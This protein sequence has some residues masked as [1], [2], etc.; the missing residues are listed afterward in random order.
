MLTVSLAHWGPVWSWN[1]EFSEVVYPG[2]LS[3]H[4]GTMK[5]EKERLL[6]SRGVSGCKTS[7]ERTRA[8]CQASKSE[9]DNLGVN[10]GRYGVHPGY[11]FRK[12]V[13][14]DNHLSLWVL[15][16]QLQVHVRTAAL[17]QVWQESSGFLQSRYPDVGQQEK[18]QMYGESC[19]REPHIDH[20]HPQSNM[21]FDD[22]EGC[23][24]S[25]AL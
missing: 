19:E 5:V 20:I 10:P 4:Q 22:D 1:G 11:Y 23:G 9:G 21:L 3:L 2:H 8:V 12:G 13:Q 18:S 14:L 7:W 17:L 6:K 16:D 15:S 25:V 24:Q